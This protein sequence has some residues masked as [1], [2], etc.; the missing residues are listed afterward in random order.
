[1]KKHETSKYLIVF[2]AV[3][4]IKVN[5]GNMLWNMNSLDSYDMHTPGEIYVYK[6]C[7]YLMKARNIDMSL[8]VTINSH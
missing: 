6:Y 7:C 3:V 8:S 4:S 1:M 5:A 2:N